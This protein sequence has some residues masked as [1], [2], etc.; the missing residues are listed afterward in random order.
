MYKKYFKR[1]LDIVL[2][3]MAILVFLPIFFV[4]II[5]GTLAMH[6]NPFFVQRRP[7]KNGKI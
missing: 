2:S 4:L 3:A 1:F 6:G 7:G 5:G